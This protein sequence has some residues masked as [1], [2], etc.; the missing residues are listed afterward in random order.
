MIGNFTHNRRLQIRLC[1]TNVGTPLNNSRSGI[2]KM[3]AKQ[4]ISD[5][6]RKFLKERI[7]TVLRLEVLLLLH[8]HQPTAFTVPEL[9]NRLGVENDITASELRQL[10]AIGV[11]VQS[12]T[13]K[14]R[15][16][17]LNETQ[18][19]LIEQLAL[20]YPKHRISILSVMLAEHPQRP[21]LFA[22]AFRIIRSND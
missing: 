7:Q 10:E 4:R 13:D 2:N 8:E 3:M 9:A 11:A 21:R 1:F 5:G 22:E 15:Y 6:L 14:Y 19:S 18:R 20:Q 17:P 12:R 16:Q